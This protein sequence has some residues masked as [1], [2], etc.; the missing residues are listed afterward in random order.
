MGVWVGVK[1][2]CVGVKVV[3]LFYCDAVGFCIAEV[4]CHCVGVRRSVGGICGCFG[5]EC[6]CVGDACCSVGF[7]LLCICCRVCCL[8]C[9][10]CV[11][12]CVWQGVVYVCVVCIVV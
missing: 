6:W 8:L 5:G 3:R 1:V 11:V 10:C 7:V 12:E 2:V 9:R 4:D